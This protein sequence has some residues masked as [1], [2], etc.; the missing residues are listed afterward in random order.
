MSAKDEIK[1]INFP[2]PSAENVQKAIKD[3]EPVPRNY[4][5]LPENMAE[6]SNLTAFFQDQANRYYQKFIAQESRK[7]LEEMLK[8]AD[9]KYRMAKTQGAQFRDGSS[10]VS[11]TLSHCP[12]S[13]F[14]KSCRLISAG[15]KDITFGNQQQ[16][17]A[18]YEAM[19]NSQDYSTM[20]GER[21]AEAQNL[22]LEY[23]WNKGEWNKTLKDSYDF[24]VKN[25][26]EVF[27]VE[28]DYRTSTR[29][30]RVPGYYTK[31]GEPVEFNPQDP[32]D[33]PDAFDVNGNPIGE[34]TDPETG[35]PMSFAFVEKT[36]TICNEPVVERKDIRHTFI[37]LDI[38]G[39]LQN[40][41]CIVFHS[42]K[43]FEYLLQNGKDG[44]FTNVDKITNGLLHDRFVDGTST[45]E[46]E[47]DENVGRD[48]DQTRTGNYDV[49]H[50]WMRAPINGK[51]EWDAN[52]IPEIYEAVFVGKLNLTPDKSDAE[53]KEGSSAV[54]V[55]LRKN[56]Y[57]HG[58]YPY[59]FAHS[60]KDER[61]GVH[62][63]FYSLLECNIE[64]QTV[65]MNQHIDN[66]TLGIKKPWVGERGN[67]LSRD[68][69]FKNGNDIKWVK[70]GTGKTALTQL[71]VKDMTGTTF[72][73]LEYLRDDADETVG[74][75]DA[76]KGQFAGSRTTATESSTATS[77][78]LKP[79]VEDVRFV[80]DQYF[81]P[82][83]RD[84]AD[85]SRQFADPR[86][87]LKLTND[88]GEI[89]D[90]NPAEL[91]GELKTKIVSIDKFQADLEAQQ[92]L[93]NFLS[94]GG[95]D[96]S[97]EFMPDTGAIKFW[98]NFGEAMRL[99]DVDEIYPESQR[100]IEAE[101]QAWADIR[102]IIHDPD[103]AL[104]NENLLPKPGE[105]H[106]VH[107]GILSS[108]IKKR[109]IEMGNVNL[110]PEEKGLMQQQILV[111]SLYVQI[112]EDLKEQEQ[113]QQAAAA[114]GSV[115]NQAGPQG[116]VPEL[117]GE[118]IGD[119]RSGIAGQI[120]G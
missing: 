32:P 80:A 48:R 60:H 62:M 1:G 91:Y 58:R 13:Q 47:M 39:S 92:V 73:T 23:V 86:Q 106:D 33:L 36:R 93:V 11:N 18:R 87:T 68:L 56:P 35:A 59:H 65:T 71:D 26:H 103:N 57:H 81:I 115:Q 113:Q 45:T 51:G 6:N 49:Y 22:Y 10:Q 38:K 94:S 100:F 69:T 105:K 84:V 16:L 34:L 37:D 116:Q 90:V 63:G 108:W 2:T 120:A 25:A 50:V 88:M 14:Y 5:Q 112:H 114:Q 24:L 109:R 110:N 43:P 85:L 61:A 75:T 15:W 64:E 9:A 117:A 52:A 54:C 31:S 99:Q 118:A 78:A 30:E 104:N 102:A 20:E 27:G 40:Q 89:Y 82:I 44:L 46:T 74:T 67:V 79:M 3:H 4:V 70:P 76:V 96:K 17:P 42:Q 12:A 101:N 41:S 107:I 98:R 83:L 111:A 66:K 7:E 29:I 55:L 95:Y 72:P 77:Q 119:T 97:V 28:W 53:A 19:T 8:D 21:M